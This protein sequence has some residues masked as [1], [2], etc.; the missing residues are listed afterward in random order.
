MHNFAYGR[1]ADAIRRIRDEGRRQGA[2]VVA[3]EEQ[4][5]QFKRAFPP[6]P[7]PDDIPNSITCLNMAFSGVAFV[8]LIV[9][10]V[11]YFGR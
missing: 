2:S 5:E 3:I 7:I 9:A 8:L 10:V 11:C 6:T 1:Y 4:V